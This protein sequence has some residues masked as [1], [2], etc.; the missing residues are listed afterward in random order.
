M[1]AWTLW[2]LNIN[3]S[4]WLKFERRQLFKAVA[5]AARRAK[6]GAFSAGYLSTA[7]GPNFGEN[8]DKSCI[9]ALS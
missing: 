1:C 3:L 6:F 9:L 8:E 5:F 7:N 2:P 4:S